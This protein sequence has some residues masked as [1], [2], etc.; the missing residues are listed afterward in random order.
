MRGFIITACAAVLAFSEAPA[1]AKPW[2]RIA[3]TRDGDSHWVDL[4]SIAQAGETRRAWIRTRYGQPKAEATHGVDQWA[5]NCQSR[6]AAVLFIVDY[7]SDGRSVAQ[8]IVRTPTW[9]PTVPESVGEARINFVCS[10]PIGTDWR[11]IEGL[12]LEQ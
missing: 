5:F 1:W 6:E 11:E 12:E 10:Y 8:E 9:L 7:N 2:A 4:A 3:A